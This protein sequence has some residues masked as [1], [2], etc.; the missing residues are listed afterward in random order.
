MFF[1]RVRQ[2]NNF[3]FTLIET[4][5][6]ISILILAIVGPLSL[7]Q[8]GIASSRF[9]KEQ[10]I[11]FYLVQDAVEEIRSRIDS[12]FLS[13]NSW[14]SGLSDCVG[15]FCEV[16]IINSSISSCGVDCDLLRKSDDGLY[17]YDSSWDETD[18]RRKIQIY[19]R[20]DTNSDEI[21]I[22]VEVLWNGDKKSFKIRESLFKLL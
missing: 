7:A 9:A 17:G 22:E 8:Q 11:A 3:G 21:Y 2:K 1:I 18:F 6:A 5:V 15:S 4:M 20:S 19:Q 14:L 13:G 16:D 10:I 12:N